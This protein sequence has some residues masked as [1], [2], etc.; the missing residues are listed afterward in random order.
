MTTT[1]LIEVTTEV[2]IT[3]NKDELAGDKSFYDIVLGKTAQKM[4]EMDMNKEYYQLKV[5]SEQKKCDC[6][7]CK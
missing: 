6:K 7:E 4:K 5:V 3:I 2:P 1:Y